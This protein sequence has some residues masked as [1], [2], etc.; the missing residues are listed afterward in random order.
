MYLYLLKVFYRARI[1]RGICAEERCCSQYCAPHQRLTGFVLCLLAQQARKIHCAYQNQVSRCQ[2]STL[3]EQLGH[4]RC[5]YTSVILCV[6]VSGP[7]LVDFKLICLRVYLSLSSFVPSTTL[8]TIGQARWEVHS[9]F[10]P[11][12]SDRPPLPQRVIL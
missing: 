8:Q 12:E 9:S 11:G 5:N 2:R 10:L 1:F 3:Q 6:R 4:S 7:Q